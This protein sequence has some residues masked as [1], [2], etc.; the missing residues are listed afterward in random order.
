MGCLGEVANSRVAAPRAQF[1]KAADYY[2]AFRSCTQIGS[3]VH[4]VIGRKPKARRSKRL[5]ILSSWPKATATS[6][7]KINFSTSHIHVVMS[8]HVNF[9]HTYYL[10]VNPPNLQV[11]SDSYLKVTKGEAQYALSTPGMD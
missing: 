8:G 9:T 11:L 3:S 5:L 7:T 2:P 4:R 1:I 6:K 10:L